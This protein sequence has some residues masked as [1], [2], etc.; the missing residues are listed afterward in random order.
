MNDLPGLEEV[1]VELLLGLFGLPQLLD[2][3]VT[4]LLGQAGPP[5]QLRDLATQVLLV[6]LQQSQGLL[7]CGQLCHG[8]MSVQ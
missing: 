3:G 5:P 7:G 4:P 8:K 6:L 1:F 2:E